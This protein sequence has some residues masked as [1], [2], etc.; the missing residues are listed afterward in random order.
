MV[1][2]ANQL[3]YS[4]GQLA[5]ARELRAKAFEA[6][7]AISGT[8]NEKPF[9][10]LA[11]ADMRLGPILEAIVDGRYFWIPFQNIREIEIEKPQDLRDLVWTPAKFTWSSGSSQWCSLR[12]AA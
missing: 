12:A 6:A 4:D 11:D 10:W 7:P 2:Q 9:E 8:I 1:V 3:A 5:Q